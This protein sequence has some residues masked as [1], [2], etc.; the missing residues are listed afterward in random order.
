M[1]AD[2]LKN[3]CSNTE[4]TEEKTESG[5]F[6][7]LRKVVKSFCKKIVSLKQRFVTMIKT[8]PV[9]LDKKSKVRVGLISVL[10][11]GVCIM[12]LF[13]TDLVTIVGAVGL[14]SLAL[15][16]IGIGIFCL[17]YHLD[18]GYKFSM[19]CV[20]VALVVA[21]VMIGLQRSGFL[22][23]FDTTEELLDFIRNNSGSI[24]EIVF[25]IIQ[26]AQVTL[27]PIP[28]TITTVCAALLFGTE[29]ITFWG[30]LKPTLLACAGSILGSMLA[31][32][33]GRVFGMRIIN[34]IL[35]KE[36]VEKYQKIVKGKDKLLLF[37]MFLFPFFPDDTLCIFA[38]LTN[39]SYL[40]FF[41]MQIF[42]RFVGVGVTVAM[43]Q[44]GDGFLGLVPFSGW[45]IPVWIF[46][47]L[48]VIVLLYL[49]FKY[50]SK[51]EQSLYRFISKITGKIHKTADTAEQNNVA[52]DSAEDN[53]ACNLNCTEDK[54][55][56]T[57]KDTSPIPII[58]GENTAE[59]DAP[60]IE[61]AEISDSTA[62][63]DTSDLSEGQSVTAEAAAADGI[64][65]DE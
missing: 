26:F 25:V 12:M 44:F 40:G 59:Q 37:F 22:S 58:S 36:A 1:N 27:I 62:T 18:S 6:A 63:A 9:E 29:T 65:D 54:Q 31:F 55:L 15:L 13:L 2:E 50:S 45:G 64:A 4:Q 49:T 48:A 11:F 39:M 51:I 3:D 14:I 30:W 46:T 5:F 42:C 24:P 17:I 7:R 38:G 52:L 28:S 8:K 57:A 32:W 47:V 41:A 23:R 43:A 61:K 53:T 19:T 33:L 21:S 20:I 34:W 56:I 60:P 35:G 16:V 10:G